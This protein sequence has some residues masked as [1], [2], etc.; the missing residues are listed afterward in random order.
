MA[1]RVATLDDLDSIRLLNEEFWQYNA[2]L[3]PDFY[4]DATDEGEYPRSVIADADADLIIA[5]ENSFIVGLIH[6]RE[7]KTPPY[8]PIIQKK[9]AEVID[10]FVTAS[11]RR[12]GV[13]TALM[14]AAK[15]WSN[16][17]NLK[18]IELFVLSEATGEKRFYESEG[19]EIAS[20]N[21]RIKI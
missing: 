9:Y 13:G 21:M 20:Y 18:Y 1:I 17:R 15:E 10:L 11:H 2:R 7:S 4:C 5:E 16:A 8:A 6:I 3:Q 12:K 19:F 14:K